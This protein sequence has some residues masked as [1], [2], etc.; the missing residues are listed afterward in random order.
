M[1]RGSVCELE[2]LC[3]AAQKLRPKHSISNATEPTSK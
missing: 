3:R 2:G 1:R